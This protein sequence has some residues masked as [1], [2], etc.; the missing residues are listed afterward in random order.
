M[1]IIYDNEGKQANHIEYQPVID[2]DPDDHSTI[3]TCISLHMHF[4]DPL[5]KKS[6]IFQ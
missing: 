2:G 5:R 1:E 3:Y 4:F 6:Q